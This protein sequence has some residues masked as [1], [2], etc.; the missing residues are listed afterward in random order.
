MN[1]NFF[2]KHSIFALL[3]L[4]FIAALLISGSFIYLGIIIGLNIGYFI[5]KRDKVENLVEF[6]EEPLVQLNSEL[7]EI[8]KILSRLKSSFITNFDIKNIAT[9]SKK[10]VV[11]LEM[12]IT[13][14]DGFMQILNN[15]F[16]KDELTYGKFLKTINEL[17][18]HIIDSYKLIK[19]KLDGIALIDNDYLNK[20]LMDKNIGKD[21][22]ISLSERKT[23]FD[24]ENK[25]ILDILME[26]EKLITDMDA[27]RVSLANI[28][29]ESN[30]AE[31]NIEYSRA[32]LRNLINNSKLYSK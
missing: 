30:I 32:M 27:I 9:I 26:N 24:K 16:N 31:I 23:I 19:N 1:I 11:Q 8:D 22:L 6:K 18:Y 5:K 13:K 21:E 20:R 10:S 7:D 4:I 3:F 15:K 25:L 14:Y 17:Y 12:V 29:T 28:N 2:K